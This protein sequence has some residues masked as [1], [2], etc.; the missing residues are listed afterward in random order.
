MSQENVEVVLEATRRFEAGD[1]AGYKEV[2]HPDVRITVPEGW[3][4][5]GPFIGQDA[6]V[7][8]YERVSADWAEQR[9]TK[10]NIVADQ[11]DWV[12]MEAHW[13]V[14]GVGSGIETDFEMAVAA[15]VQK[16][17]LIEGHWRW[18]QEDAL[19]AVGLSE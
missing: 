2:A 5:Q 19:E 8:Q 3:P 16:G 13:H 15:R 7:G 6:V 17:L 18:N 1:W 14:R 10:V 12:V 9:I 4:E 11:G